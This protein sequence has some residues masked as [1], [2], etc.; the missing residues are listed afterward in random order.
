M[1][2]DVQDEDLAQ[3]DPEDVP[4][5]GSHTEEAFGHRIQHL[6]PIEVHSDDV[7][8]DALGKDPAVLVD[9]AHT[10]P[11]VPS[12]HRPVEAN[13]GR[14]LLVLGMPPGAVLPGTP[15]ARH[16]FP[17]RNRIIAAVARAVVV[18]EAPH[19][20]GALSTAARAREQGKDV[21]AVPGPVGSRASE[22]T[23]ALIRDGVTMVTSA[24]E[25]LDNLRLPLPPSDAE[26]DTA[27]AGLEGQALALWRVLAHG[28]LHADEVAARAGL[29]PHR[30]LASLLSL[31]LQGHARQLPGLRFTRA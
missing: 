2:G 19:G 3:A 21:F 22:G 13:Q 30:G 23:N 15:P 26:L 10:E 28:P 16:A 20:S 1:V 4:G 31:E 25:V 8:K 5:L 14:R 7:M 12:V 27:P 6:P 17:R 9:E 18:V 11:P 29:D 24:R